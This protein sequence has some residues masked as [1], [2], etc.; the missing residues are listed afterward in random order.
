ME[1]GETELAAEE[2]H[3][4]IASMWRVQICMAYGI[5]QTSWMYSVYVQYNRPRI[6]QSRGLRTQP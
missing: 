5:G 2:R 3:C 6:K 4:I 1:H